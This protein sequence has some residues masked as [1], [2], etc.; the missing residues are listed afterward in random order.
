MDGVIPVELLGSH[1]RIQREFSAH[2]S[3]HRVLSDEIFTGVMPPY[4]YSAQ[5]IKYTVQ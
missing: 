3:A 4:P 5:N 2:V 1:I